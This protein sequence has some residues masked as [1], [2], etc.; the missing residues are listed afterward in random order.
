MMTTGTVTLSR[1]APRSA[2]HALGQRA[3][4]NPESEQCGLDVSS[5]SEMLWMDTTDVGWFVS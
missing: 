1:C 5:S 3:L 4:Y 2:R